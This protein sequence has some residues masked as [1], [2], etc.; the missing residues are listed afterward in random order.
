MP[1]NRKITLRRR[2]EGAP[3]PDD[4]ATTEVPVRDPDAG[5]VSLRTIYLSIDP[6]MRGRMSAAASYVAPLQLGDVITGE[7]VSEVLTSRAPGIAAGDLVVG[8]TGWQDHP[9]V[10]ADLL[11]PVDRARGPISTALGVLGMPGFTAWAGL[12][13]IG[14]PRAGETLAVAAATGPVGSAVG[15]I[16]KIRGARTVG[17]AGGPDK[18]AYAVT[19]LGFDACIDRH[20]DDFDQQL[21]AACPDGVDVYWENV[22][23]P[24]FASVLPRLND[25]ARVPVC[26]LVAHYNATKRPPGPDN[27]PGLMRQILIRRLRVQGF[28]VF[29]YAADRPRFEDEMA[30]WVHDGRVRHREDV[31]DGLDAAPGALVG[32]LE[33]ANFGK[34]LVR[35]TD[36]PAEPGTIGA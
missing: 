3:T 4:F 26:G 2:P 24:V 15:Q 18:C 9:T 21:A 13:H 17:I 20:A 32:M 30:R 8:Y 31:V 23:G 16:A 25:F 35:V 11:R 36:P 29:D 19:E 10:R 12:E 1:T 6:Y 7:A 5:E 14:R 28:I 33:G 34:L 22:G 27:A